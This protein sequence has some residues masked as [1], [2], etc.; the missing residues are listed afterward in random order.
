[1]KSN[2]TPYLYYLRCNFCNKNVYNSIYLRLTIINNS[3]IVNTMWD[4]LYECSPPTDSHY[5]QFLTVL[6]L[7]FFLWLYER[8][9]CLHEAGLP[10][11]LSYSQLL[12]TGYVS[13]NM[14]RHSIR[15]YRVNKI[16]G[17]TRWIS[18]Q[19]NRLCL[20]WKLQHFEGF[21]YVAH[22]TAHHFK[23]LNWFS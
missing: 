18:E 7:W 3:I 17:I 22:R 19:R 5:V 16:D 21:H 15:S 1:M 13:P 9:H 23:L 20:D 4:K 8:M 14:T 12:H 6:Y 10:E 2:I 11:T